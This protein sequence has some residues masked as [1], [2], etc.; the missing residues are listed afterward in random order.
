MSSTPEGPR[1][2]PPAPESRAPESR[3]PESRDVRLKR[4]RF[5]S[6]H[7]GFKEADLIL[8]HFADTHLHELTPEQ[9][10]RYEALLAEEDQVLYGWIVGREP[11][12]SR[13]DHDVMAMIRS[14]SHLEERL[15][16][17]QNRSGGPPSI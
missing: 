7:R 8:G 1:T 12:P 15:W 16:P 6:W 3:A 2:E 17:G 4:L 10:D 9:L 5:R 11:V 14:L 13:L